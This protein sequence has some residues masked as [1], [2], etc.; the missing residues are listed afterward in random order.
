MSEQKFVK[1]RGWENGHA[2]YV[3]VEHEWIAGG[4]YE[5]GVLR[6]AAEEGG[7]YWSLEWDAQRSQYY[8]GSFRASSDRDAVA[9]LAMG[10]V[11]DRATDVNGDIRWEWIPSWMKEW[12]YGDVHLRRFDDL[13]ESRRQGLFDMLIVGRSAGESSDIARVRGLEDL[14]LKRYE[15]RDAVASECMRE[16]LSAVV[17]EL[18]HLEWLAGIYSEGKW[19]EG[20]RACRERFGMVVEEAMREA[21]HTHI[22]RKSFRPKMAEMR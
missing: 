20:V 13:D 5:W 18:E 6:S 22:L 3:P 10:V 15:G 16:S 2:L 11:I 12:E 19:D 14:L 7:E 1:W 4:P 17:S 9:I 8:A 21:R